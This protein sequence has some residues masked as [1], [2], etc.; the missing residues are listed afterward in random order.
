MNGPVGKFLLPVG[1]TPVAQAIFEYLAH[2]KLPPFP[3]WHWDD[4]VHV[5]TYLVAAAGAV[6]A[7][8]FRPRS[9]GGKAV[10]IFIP[11]ILLVVCYVVYKQVGFEPPPYK[12]VRL[13]NEGGKGLFFLTYMLFGFVVARVVRTIATEG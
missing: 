1:A 3:I 5:I 7:C 6:I 4:N 13:I 9:N 10:C 8:L 12:W 11:M 2:L